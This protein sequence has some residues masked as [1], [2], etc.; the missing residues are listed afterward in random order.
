MHG[1]G[2]KW[3]GVKGAREREGEDGRVWGVQGGR[4]KGE[5]VREREGKGGRGWE[6]RGSGRVG[7]RAVRGGNGWER[8][9][10]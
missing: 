6:V 7:E 3:E 9:R 5:G 10:G 4:S 8:G 2:S 1:R